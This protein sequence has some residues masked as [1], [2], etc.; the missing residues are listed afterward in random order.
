[1]LA[2][3]TENGAT[4]ADTCFL[5]ARVAVE[6][7]QTC[8]AVN[9]ELVLKSP[10]MSVGI[11]V[12][13]KGSATSFDGFFQNMLDA[14]QEKLDFFVAEALNGASWKNMCVKKRFIGVDIP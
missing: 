6:A 9:H 8:S 11:P 4:A 14:C 5:Q 7:G 10:S 2:V 3:G 1:M 12:V 13:A